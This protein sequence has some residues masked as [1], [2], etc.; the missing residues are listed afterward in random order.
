MENY[1]KI[2]QIMMINTLYY[3]KI[4]IFKEYL[5]REQLI[6]IILCNYFYYFWNN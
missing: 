6:K 4:Y 1:S 2:K 5:K 3:N